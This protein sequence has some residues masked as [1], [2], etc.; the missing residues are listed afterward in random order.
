MGKAYYCFRIGVFSE[1]CGM[2][3]ERV[4]EKINAVLSQLPDK[5]E[6][7]KTERLSIV[8]SL[9]AHYI[10]I[11]ENPVFTD[12]TSVEEFLRNKQDNENEA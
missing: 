9:A 8:D 10:A 11:F 12:N 2:K 1:A 4:A 3:E 5:T 6:L 7:V